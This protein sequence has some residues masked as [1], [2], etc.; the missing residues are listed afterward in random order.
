MTDVAVLGQMSGGTVFAIGAHHL[1]ERAAVGKLWVQLFAEITES[2]RL[3][4][5]SFADNGIDMLHEAGSV[6]RGQDW[7]LPGWGLRLLLRRFLKHCRCAAVLL[8][9]VLVVQGS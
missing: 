4:F 1:V 7:S 3:N 9:R 8:Q 5:E 2:P 6:R